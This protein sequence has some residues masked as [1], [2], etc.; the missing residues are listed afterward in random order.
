MM[1]QIKHISLGADSNRAAAPEAEQEQRVAIFDILE[2]NTFEVQGL[3]GPYDLVMQKESGR[4]QFALT[5]AGGSTQ[6]LTV[7]LGPM[8]QVMKDYTQICSGYYEAVKTKSVAEIE[9]LDDARR[10]I[11]GEGGRMLGERMGD[12]VST[13]IETARRLFTLLCTC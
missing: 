5:G 11:H 13:D 6:A 10:Q 12:A 7:A 4:V 8:R 1:P 3:T 2:E 9:A